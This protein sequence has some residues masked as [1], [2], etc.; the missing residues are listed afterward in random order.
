MVAA[1]FERGVLLREHHEVMFQIPPAIFAPADLRR[2]ART[3]ERDVHFPSPGAPWL[4]IKSNLPI[5]PVC[6]WSRE[7]RPPA[8][9]GVG[10]A[11]EAAA[12]FPAVQ[13]ESRGVDR[14]TLPQR[15]VTIL[16]C[17]PGWSSETVAP[18]QPIPVID[19]VSHRHDLF[20]KSWDHSSAGSVAPR[21]ED[22]CCSLRTYRARA[23]QCGPGRSRNA[24]P[25]RCLRASCLTKS[26]EPPKSV[27]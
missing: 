18:A 19:V 1:H 8:S 10:G 16:T 6:R 5:A 22:N 20:P 14:L 7:A 15:S 21:P 23:G 12:H 26:Q 24:P 2:D 9:L 25:P 4:R 11:A 27:S 3:Q 13:D 17:S